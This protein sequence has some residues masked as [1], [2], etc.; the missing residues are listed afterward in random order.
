MTGEPD[1]CRELAA[2]LT[3][4]EAKEIADRL[5]AGQPLI[6][7][8]KVVALARRSQARGL[9]ER[10]GLGQHLLTGTVSVLR[11]IEGAHSHVTS[12]GTV[13][14]APSHLAQQGQLTASIHHYVERA[15]ES[16]ICSTYNFQRSSAL[17][18]ALTSASARP[19][20]T[21]RI[22]M[23]TAAADDSP[24]PWKPTTSQVA[25]AMRG[26][27]VLRTREVSGQ[28]VRNHAKFVAVDHQFLIVTSANFSKSAEQHNIELGLV[29]VDALVAQ[30]VE[31][32]MADFEPYAYEV[33]RRSSNA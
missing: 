9:I 16:V 12:I 19:E 4:T 11:A 29:I 32:Q 31:R 15:R 2:Y 5:T 23:D 13:W 25:V 20:V 10:A 21:V 26:A 6:M 14:T 8:T 33:V 22:Y 28:L 30:A 18:A 3:G 27:T 7:A 1:A 24:A 17:W